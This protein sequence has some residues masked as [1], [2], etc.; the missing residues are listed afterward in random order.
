MTDALPATHKAVQL[1]SYDGPA[2]LSV[3]DKP[4]PRPGPT[5]VL[6]RVSAAPI[7]PSDVMFTRG[8]Y[9]FK[10]PLPTVPGFEASGVVVAAGS[11][12]GRAHVGRRVA[13]VAGDKHDGTWA[14]YAVTEL[15]RCFPLRGH[16]TDEQ[17]AMAIVNPLTAWGMCHVA[18]SDG[19]KAFVHTAAASALGRFLVVLAKKKGIPVIHVVRR[20]E[21]RE[22]LEQLG[23]KHVLDSST[24]SFPDRLRERTRT[25]GA[26]LAF[27][28][29]AGPMTGQLL[30]CMP[31]NSRV[32]LYG[33]LSE[34]PVSL[35]PG[36][37]IFSG[38]SLDGFYLT[39]LFRPQTL[40][41]LLLGAVEV[42]S[43]LGESHTTTVASRR[44]L[45][46]APKAVAEY[47][48]DMTA[49]KVLLVPGR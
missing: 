49:G 32:R 22:L 1:V 43:L 40:P 4:L 2:G 17:G 16:I 27:D 42:Q 15:T 3:I 31:K 11:L 7:N 33:A 10:K 13:F 41:Q 12:L 18:Q 8:L 38:K 20:A 14:E 35:N 9:G 23:A 25:L 47:L 19:H 26:T 5:E 44:R 37:L 21:Q 39:E 36:A 45:D 34:Q 6:I 28:A 24:K 30:E 48:A 29:V 46:D